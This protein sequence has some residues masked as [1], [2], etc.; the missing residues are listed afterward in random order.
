[1]RITLTNDAFRIILDH[2]RQQ[3]PLEACGLIAGRRS[4]DFKEVTRVYPLKNQTQSR[5]RFDIDPRDQLEAIKK[6]RSEGLAPLGN[7][8]SH[9]ETPARPSDE[10]LKLYLDPNAS[11]LIMSLANRRPVLKS[12]ALV[13]GP[14]PSAVEEELEITTL[15]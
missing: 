3:F 13:T 5:F 12:F 9:P 4:D 1:M 14:N 7:Y 8:H 11:Y 15:R 6:M 10:D 2:C